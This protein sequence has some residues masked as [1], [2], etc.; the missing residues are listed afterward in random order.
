[1]KQSKI[2]TRTMQLILA[3]IIFFSCSK[4]SDEISLNPDGSVRGSGTVPPTNYTAKIT[5]S[6]NAF[7]PA[8]VT[9]MQSGSLLWVNGDTQ[10]HTVTADDGSFGYTFN[11][12][13]PHPYHCK[14]HNE[15]TGLVK[16]VTK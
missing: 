2:F 6:A 8:E 5:I 14:Y 7:T 9:V 1:M 3:S 4:S 16:C 13:G 11:I 10:V 12:I 15:Q